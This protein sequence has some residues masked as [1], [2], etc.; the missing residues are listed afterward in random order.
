M[1]QQNKGVGGRGGG[2]LG[3][4]VLSGHTL[5]ALMGTEQSGGGSSSE[6][7]PRTGPK[8]GEGLRRSLFLFPSPAPVVGAPGDDRRVRR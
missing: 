2:S 1:T 5:G 3:T 8:A 6:Q 4:A 7:R